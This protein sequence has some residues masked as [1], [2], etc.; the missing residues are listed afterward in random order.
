M[1]TTT[2]DNDR[3]PG[4]PVQRIVRASPCAIPARPTIVQQIKALQ[5]DFSLFCLAADARRHSPL[6]RAQAFAH[7]AALL[8][9][10]T[11]PRAQYV[12]RIV[13]A[14]GISEKSSRSRI[15]RALDAGAIVTIG[16]LGDRSYRRPRTPAEAPQ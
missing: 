7:T 5:H 8:G 4:Y 2:A 1:S 6:M 14:T 9:D 12:A 10:D 13:K 16:R 3:T 15:Q 11:L